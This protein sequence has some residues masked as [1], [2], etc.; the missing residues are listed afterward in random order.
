MR[1]PR[2][3]Q[4]VGDAEDPPVVGPAGRAAGR[5]DELR[6]ARQLGDLPERGRHALTVEGHQLVG[7]WHAAAGFREELGRLPAPDL[8][9]LVPALV[10]PGHPGGP[11]RGPQVECPRGGD[12]RSGQRPRRQA[13]SA[14]GRSAGHP[15]QVQPVLPL[16]CPGHFVEL[17][18]ALGLEGRDGRLGQV[19]RPPVQVTDHDRVPAARAPSRMGRWRIE[20]DAAI[21]AGNRY[22]GRGLLGLRR[23]RRVLHRRHDLRVGA[24]PAQKP[25]KERDRS[26]LGSLAR[27]GIVHGIVPRQPPGRWAGPPT[28]DTGT[29]T[30]RG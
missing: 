6:L 4:L 12:R 26:H 24:V 3:A 28:V 11:L 29:G 17:T 21:R 1:Q 23:G 16:A 22:D 27:S 14:V 18:P 9:Q 10:A 5:P 25:P 19:D 30:R 7:R 20:G 15:R 8:C 13:A 2:R